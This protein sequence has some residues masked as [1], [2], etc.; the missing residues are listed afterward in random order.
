MPEAIFEPRLRILA[1][2]ASYGTANDAYL[3]RLIREYRSMPFDIDIVVTSN[4]DKQIAPGVE[5][6]V[7][8]PNSDPWSLPFQHKKVFVERAHEYDLFIYS[9]DDMLITE[10]NI[11]AFLD[12]SKSLHGNEIAGYLR[13]EYDPDHNV[14]YPDAHAH[15][16][17]DPSSV[18]TRGKYTLAHFTNEHAACYVLTREHLTR[19]IQSGQFLVEPHEWKYDLACT[20]AT[21]PYTQ[22]GFKK[23]IPISHLH[24]FIVWHLSNKYI[25]KLGI[26]GATMQTQI[27]ALQ[28]LN[29]SGCQGRTLFKTDTM[30]RRRMHSKDYYEPINEWV[31]SL[32][33]KQTRRVLSI[34]CGSGAT[35]IG[36]LQKGIEVVA[37]PLDTVISA[38][39]AARGVQMVS[40]DFIEAKA[41]LDKE[42]FDCILYLNVLHLL[43][44]PIHILSLFADITSEH[45]ITV[46][47]VPNMTF[48]KNIRRG[49]RAIDST[50]NWAAYSRTGV[51]PTR[52]RLIRSWCIS[53]GLRITK[54]LYAYPKGA[55]SACRA[56]PVLFAPELIA[57]A[58]Q[59][60]RKRRLDPTFSA[61]G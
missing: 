18:R 45:A 24:S 5:L 30:L 48:Y 6:I 54:M 44:D 42:T 15:Y 60:R 17:W 52:A 61:A 16:H 43:P 36:L 49:I 22:C 53:S 35:E 27:S 10:D 41:K 50:W 57:V 29:V 55:N 32:I 25:G 20:A 3:L 8:L 13:V 51:H 56:L 2:L 39:A 28:R 9:E 4:V 23:L 19:A 58:Q 46:I 21:D 31:A 38:E 34:G 7:G 26:N 14:S 47:Q 33:P 1:V 12:V 11:N 37:L 40:G 59:D